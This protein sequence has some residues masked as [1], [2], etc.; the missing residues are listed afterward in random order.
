MYNLINRD[1]QM[2]NLM[3]FSV[4]IYVY[5]Y[6]HL[7]FVTKSPLLSEKDKKKFV[8]ENAYKFYKFAN[9]KQPE[10]IKIY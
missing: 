7:D 6:M 9:L 3:P 8:G 4:I 10:Y 5:F 2:K 1:I